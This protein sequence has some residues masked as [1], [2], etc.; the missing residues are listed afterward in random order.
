MSEKLLDFEIV[1][2]VVRHYAIAEFQRC[3][4]D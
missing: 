3:G 4:A 1:P 2:D